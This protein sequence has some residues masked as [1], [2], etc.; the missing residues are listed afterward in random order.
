MDVNAR[1]LQV[2]KSGVEIECGACGSESLLIRKPVY[3][4]LKKLGETFSCAGCGHIFE[5]EED[6]PFKCDECFE[7]FD[8]AELAGA[9]KVFRED[10]RGVL[11]R[12]CSHY[13]VNPFTQ[14]CDLHRKEVAATDVCDD[15]V[16][17]EDEEKG[18]I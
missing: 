9:D 15:F 17:Q 5:S 13:V 10:E 1:G 12:Y 14:W 18:V 16:R 3:E 11:C 7:V 6:I 4:G 8:K 2:K